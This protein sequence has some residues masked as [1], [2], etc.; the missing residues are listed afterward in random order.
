MMTMNQSTL[1]PNVKDWFKCMK[2]KL[3]SSS[4][5]MTTNLA[6]KS[7]PTTIALRLSWNVWLSA[8]H[9]TA[10]WCPITNK[11]VNHLLLIFLS[12]LV[13][14]TI[15]NIRTFPTCKSQ[16][17]RRK[18]EFVSSS[19]N[20]KLFSKSSWIKR[21]NRIRCICI[22]TLRRMM[23]QAQV[24]QRRVSLRNLMCLISCISCKSHRM[25]WRTLKWV[26]LWYFFGGEAFWFCKL[27]VRRKLRF[28][29]LFKGSSI[30]LAFE[31]SSEAFY[32]FLHLIVANNSLFFSIT[33][34]LHISLTITH[35]LLIEWLYLSFI[36]SLSAYFHIFFHHLQIKY[37]GWRLWS[38]D[39]KWVSVER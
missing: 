36:F 26:D 14:H 4:S 19:A 22:C 28:K 6:K 34:Y 11:L 20:L 7:A 38:S 9:V 16:L 17:D 24:H 23:A 8:T 18:R 31:P 25:N 1:T 27:L 12:F 10:T 37:L 33:L 30:N 39:W 2:K 5:N 35:H 3:R 13:G 15:A 29:E 32:N 21:I